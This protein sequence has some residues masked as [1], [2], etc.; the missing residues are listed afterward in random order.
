MSPDHKDQLS[1]EIPPF[2][3]AASLGYFVELGLFPAGWMFVPEL[4]AFRLQFL[5]LVI[6][7]SLTESLTPCLSCPGQ[8]DQIFGP[9][10]ARVFG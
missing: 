10:K 6:T 7:V 1:T 2:L 3:N 4:P 9:K 8:C 5:C